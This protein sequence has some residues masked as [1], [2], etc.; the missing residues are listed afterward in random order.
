MIIGIDDSGDFETDPKSLYAAVFIRPKKYDRIIKTFTSWEDGL[1]ASVKEGGE[2][3]GWLLSIDQLAEFT[4]RVLINNGYG[5][6]KLG[7][8]MIDVDEHNSSSLLGQRELNLTQIKEGV[9][10]NYRNNGDEYRKIIHQYSQMSAWLNA[11]SVKTLYKIE[12]L[13]IAIVKSFNLAIIVSVDK[14]FDKELGKLTMSIDE[15]IVGRKSVEMYW[16]DLLRNQFWSLTST[17]EPI[18]Q[19][20]TWRANHPYVKR[21]DQYPGST[22]SLSQ[23]NRSEIDKVFN[24]YNSNDKPEIRIADIVASTY[25]RYFVQG[26]KN[27]KVVIDRMVSQVIVGKPFTLIRMAKGRHP[28]AKNPYEDEIEGVTIDDLRAKYEN[29]RQGSN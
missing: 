26:E 12:L 2:V 6:I 16:R 27:L 22:E 24:F 4:D 23:F 7:V 9:D 19:L 29:D 14:R 20:T 17:V 28:Y 3:K 21:F 15:G 11:K 1:P 5:A 10:K 18:I 25:F 8:F 13:G